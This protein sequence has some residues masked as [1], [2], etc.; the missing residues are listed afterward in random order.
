LRVAVVEAVVE[1]VA[2]TGGA[3]AADELALCVAGG[4]FVVALLEPLPPHAEAS[5]PAASAI[6]AS[7]LRRD[8]TTLKS[9][10]LAG[11]AWRSASLNA[12]GGARS[13]A[14]RPNGSPGSARS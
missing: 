4:D 5:A 2:G 12:A 9:P 11:P 6:T 8:L 7:S 14:G 13:G 1:L 10:G 3:W